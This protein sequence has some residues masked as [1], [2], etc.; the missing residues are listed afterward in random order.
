VSKRGDLSVP[1]RCA[2]PQRCSIVVTR[3]LG[4]LRHSMAGTRS[5]RCDAWRRSVA[6]GGPNCSADGDGPRPGLRIRCVSPVAR[7]GPDRS[8]HRGGV[9]VNRAAPTTCR[10]QC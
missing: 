1:R 6:G 9:L 3:N 2:E 5:S 8:S 10:I 4:H 7:S